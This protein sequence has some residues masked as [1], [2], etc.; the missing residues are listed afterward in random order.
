MVDASA[1]SMSGEPVL[2]GLV[3]QRIA[4]GGYWQ[5]VPDLFAVRSCDAGVCRQGI[6][7]PV[8]RVIVQHVGATS[9]TVTF[10]AHYD[11][12]P[13]QTLTNGLP[14]STMTT[15]MSIPAGAAPMLKNVES[16]G[17][18]AELPYGQLRK[19]MLPDGVA[20]GLCLSD[21]REPVMPPSGACPA[22]T[23]A[24]FSKAL[25]AAAQF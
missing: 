23:D 18:T 17:H 14:A 11:V 9:A 4:V 10:Q 3:T 25:A 1:G 15:T 20:L 6:A 24:H 7:K 19:I 22:A 5:V 13:S 12:G 8:A 16:V 21:S 2:G